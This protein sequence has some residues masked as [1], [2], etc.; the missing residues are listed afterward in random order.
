LES[1]IFTRARKKFGAADRRNSATVFLTP[2]PLR[3]R[4]SP[5]RYGPR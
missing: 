1:W 3:S 2:K 4:P 5:R